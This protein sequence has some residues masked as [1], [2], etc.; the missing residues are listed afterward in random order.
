MNA[1]SRRQFRASRANDA[2][3]A[4]EKYVHVLSFFVCVEINTILANP[5][6]AGDFGVNLGFV[7]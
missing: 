1:A 7:N 4:N 2:C 5:G 6:E 3:T